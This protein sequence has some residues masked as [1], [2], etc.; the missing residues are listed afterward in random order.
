MLSCHSFHAVQT[1][2]CQPVTMPNQNHQ[3]AGGD[4]TRDPGW[5]NAQ[6]YGCLGTLCQWWRDQGMHTRQSCRNFVRIRLFR[7]SSWYSTHTF[8]EVSRYFKV[9]ISQIAMSNS[10]Q[11]TTYMSYSNM[12]VPNSCQ[13]FHYSHIIVVPGI[14]EVIC[15]QPQVQLPHYQT[16][17]SQLS[18][19]CVPTLETFQLLLHMASECAAW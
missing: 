6:D 4:C 2:P 19:D 3:T 18:C 17:C 10:S 11:N 9:Y 13:L 7:S 14:A 5:G 15:G 12:H 8:A 16:D 1:L